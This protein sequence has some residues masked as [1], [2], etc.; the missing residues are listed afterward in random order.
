MLVIIQPPGIH[1]AILPFVKLNIHHIS[2]ARKI[3]ETRG[4]I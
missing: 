2:K 3:E 4:D 1:H